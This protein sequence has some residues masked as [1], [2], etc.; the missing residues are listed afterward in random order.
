MK[1]LLDRLEGQWLDFWF[2]L[3]DTRALDLVRI[4]IGLTLLLN[5]AM[6]AGHIAEFYSDEGWLPTALSLDLFESSDISLLFGFKSPA[7]VEALWWVLLAAA[8]AFT[9]GWRT[10]ASKWVLWILHT[11]FAKRAPFILYGVDDICSNLLFI[12]CL[13]VVG[14]SM[15]LDAR[16]RARQKND[17]P[18]SEFNRAR[19]SAGL[20]LAQIQMAI[21]FFFAGAEK[22]QGEDWWGGDAIWYAMTDYEFTFVPLT[23]LAERPWLINAMTYGALGIEISYGFLIWD[24]R[25]RLPLL[26]TAISLHIGVALMM[27]LVLFGIAMIAGHLAFMRPAW[28]DATRAW[29]QSKLGRAGP[30]L[31]T[32]IG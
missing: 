4:G 13:G 31:A 29:L 7:A 26:V 24:P 12:M 17:R 32:E 19:A 3:P 14:R 30:P 23:P 22:L 27:G 18:L 1:A 21:C 20:R 6:Q 9:L 25:F 5:Y 10:S 11:S 8:V 28:I 2:G 15:S 16:R